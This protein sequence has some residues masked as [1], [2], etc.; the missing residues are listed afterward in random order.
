MPSYIGQE[1]KRKEDP[2]LITGHGVYT[3]DVDVPGMLHVAFVR[4]PYPHARIKSINTEAAKAVPG[5]EA[6]ITFEDIKGTNPNFIP[7]R[8]PTL[9]WAPELR[10]FPAEKVTFVGQAVAA[11]AA[12]DPY[13]A[14]D[15]ADLVEVDF[16]PLPS[17][18]DPEKAMGPDAPVIWPEAGGNVCFTLKSGSDEVDELMAKADEKVTVRVVN[19][20]VAAVPIEGR[21]IMVQPD[22]YNDGLTVTIATQQPHNDRSGIAAILGIPENKVR[23]ITRDVGGAFGAKGT[24]YAEEACVAFLAKTLQRPVNWAETRSENLATMTAGRAHIQE[25]TL[26]VNRDGKLQALDVNAVADIGGVLSPIGAASPFSIMS[27]CA[28]PYVWPAARA[29]LKGVYTNCVPTGPYRGAGR[30]EATLALE[31]AMDAAARKIGMDPVELRRRNLIAADAFP[32]TTTVGPVYDSGNYQLALDMALKGLDYDHWRAEQ[33]RLRDQG[34]YIGIGVTT[35]VEPAGAGFTEFGEIRVERSGRV[36]LLHGGA[37]SGQGHQTV[38]A[39]IVASELGVPMD[40]VEVLHG[41]TAAIP[42]GV[43]TFGSRS[44]LL[45]GSLTLGLSQKMKGKM[46][47]IAANLLEASPADIQLDEGKFFVAGTPAKAMGF[48]DVAGAAHMGR[49]LSEGMEPGLEIRETY[50]M[51]GTAYPFGTHVAV[52][53]VD[54]DTGMVQVLRYLGVDDCGVMINPML[55]TGQLHGGFAQ[56]FGEVFMEQMRYDDSGHMLSATLMDYALPRASNVPNIEFEHTETPSPLNPL[57][58]KGVGEAGTIASPPTLINA[59]IDALSPLGVTDLQMPLSAPRVWA[60]IQAAKGAK[61][62]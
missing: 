39:Q 11:V 62:A 24:V 34:R 14:R 51:H 33:K 60:A 61:A 28:G 8:P 22:G 47:E 46:S 27:M 41:D 54:V 52:V 55:V 50:A 43:G 45:G 48:N 17:V 19:N 53:E 56:A 1:I 13:T 12:D 35:F 10:I 36:T 6:V 40:N 2:R 7:F 16:E 37:P 57:G 21:A 26:G 4:S 38:Y 15:A 49:G 29:Q 31:R 5:V 18:S 58:A 3:D 23:L 44:G 20:R 42:R 9:T 32:Y 25:V 59:C 30:P